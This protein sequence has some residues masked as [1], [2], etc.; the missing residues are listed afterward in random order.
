LA[1]VKPAKARPGG[2]TERTRIAVLRATLDE[3]AERGFAALTVEAVAER[4]GVHKTTVYRRWRNAEG[5]VAEALALGAEQHWQVPD[6]GSLEGDL[7]GLTAELVY[8]FTDPGVSALPIASIF[9]AFQ[10]EQAA[11]ALHTFYL[12]RHERSAEIVRRAVE[13]GEVPTGTDPVE[14]I[15]AACAP[16]FYRLFISREPVTEAVARTAGRATAIAATAGA[17]VCDRAAA[18]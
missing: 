9:A 13:R 18:G 10:S 17:Y 1:T 12:N 5:L 11:E 14:V 4:S 2:R 7:A 15:R 16:I 6:T 8:Y 3:L